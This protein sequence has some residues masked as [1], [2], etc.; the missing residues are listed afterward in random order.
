MSVIYLALSGD[1]DDDDE[2][3]V[4]SLSFE[5]VTCWRIRGRRARTHTQRRTHTRDGRISEPAD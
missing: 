4:S 5:P 1:D 3:G 2:G